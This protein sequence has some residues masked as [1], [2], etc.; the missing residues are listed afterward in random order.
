MHGNKGQTCFFYFRVVLSEMNRSV[1][2][3]VKQISV[4]LS[5]R[6]C[7]DAK[8]TYIFVFQNC[9]MHDFSAA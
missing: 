2:E 6:A 1:K 3:N 8:D 9:E 4:W 5:G 7:R